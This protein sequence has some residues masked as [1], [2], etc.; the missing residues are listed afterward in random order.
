MVVA[1]HSILF[2]ASSIV[3]NTTFN[4]ALRRRAYLCYVGAVVARKFRHACY[5]RA[6]FYRKPHERSFFSAGRQLSQA[7]VNVF[8]FALYSPWKGG[9]S[10][11]SCSLVTHTAD[12]PRTFSVFRTRYQPLLLSAIARV[13]RLSCTLSLIANLSAFRSQ[14]I[15]RSRRGAC[16]ILCTVSPC[17]RNHQYF[18]CKIIVCG[19]FRG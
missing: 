1:Q 18:T 11:F 4:F 3:G 15:S 14:H 9:R 16:E 6:R 7:G 2:T 8:R 10:I 12:L 5:F 13:A 19:I 17:R